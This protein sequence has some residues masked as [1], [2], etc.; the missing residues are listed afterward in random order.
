MLQPKVFMKRELTFISK[1][2]KDIKGDTAGIDGINRRMS[3]LQ[4]REKGWE[5]CPI[6]TLSG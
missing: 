1:L 2:V 4:F 5:S 3:D 6:E